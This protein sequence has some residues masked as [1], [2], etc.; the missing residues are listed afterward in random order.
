M[1]RKKENDRRKERE[2]E[3]AMEVEAGGG[4]D[5]GGKGGLGW[6]RRPRHRDLHRFAKMLRPLR[7]CGPDWVV[8]P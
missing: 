6:L 4:G 1:K 7:P 8:R 5:E 2:E 3:E